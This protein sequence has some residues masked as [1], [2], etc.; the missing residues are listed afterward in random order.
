MRKHRTYNIDTDEQNADWLKPRF[1]HPVEQLAAKPHP[2]KG[3]WVM[4][5]GK[6]IFVPDGGT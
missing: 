6:K 4:T 5:Q 1:L 3:R 2:K